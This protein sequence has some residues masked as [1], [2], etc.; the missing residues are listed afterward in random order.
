MISSSLPNERSKSCLTF[1]ALTTGLLVPM[2]TGVLFYYK[3]LGCFIV[4]VEVADLGACITGEV[5]F[6]SFPSNASPSTS[7]IALSSS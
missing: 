2:L 6:S 1:Y 5:F 3:A 7:S 4:F